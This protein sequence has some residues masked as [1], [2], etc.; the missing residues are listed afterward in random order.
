MPTKPVKQGGINENYGR[1]LMELHTIGVDAGY[2]Q[3]DVQEVA[4]CFTGWSID[5]VTR[6]VHGVPSPRA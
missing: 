1:E 5:R 2:T 3:K 6:R 4:R